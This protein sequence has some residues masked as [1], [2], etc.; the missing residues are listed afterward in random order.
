LVGVWFHFLA[1]NIIFPDQYKLSET[2]S[3]NSAS[4]QACQ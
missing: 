3:K 4:K 1:I 2:S